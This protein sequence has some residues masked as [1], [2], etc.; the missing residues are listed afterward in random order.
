MLRDLVRIESHSSQPSGVH[1]VGQV[2]ADELSDI[3]FTIERAPQPKIDPR[4]RWLAEVLAPDHPYESLADTVVARRDGSG[5]DRVL[6][7]GDLDTAFDPGAVERFPFTLSDGRAYGPGVADMKGGLVVMVAALR[8]LDA[9]RMPTPPVAIVLSG[10]EQAGSLGSREVIAAEARSSRWCLCLECARDGGKLMAARAHVGVALV[11]VR[12]RP[13]HAGTAHRAGINAIDALVDLLPALTSLADL[14]SDVLVTVTL[15]RGGHRRSV[16]PD[17]ATAVLDLR[18][19]DPA[20]WDGLVRRLTT[21]AGE[22]NDRSPAEVRLRVAAHRPGVAWTASTDELLE[23]V[24]RVGA[25]LG[26]EVAA[27]RSNA[28]GSSAFAAEVGAVVLDG[29]GPSGRDLMTSRESIDV[30]S[31]VERAALLAAC[32]NRLADGPPGVPLD[33]GSGTRET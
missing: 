17:T 26:V 1:R 24:E 15:I 7:L 31:I 8:A 28:A 23:L 13:A 27:T 33:P 18:T 6:L 12:G 10:D 5:G 11:E 3:G 9:L 22:A 20:A 16:V 2:I 29:M 30:D 21:S 14:S 19:P 4:M 32:I 25:E